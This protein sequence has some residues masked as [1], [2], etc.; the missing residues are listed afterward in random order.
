MTANGV[1]DGGGE[2]KRNVRGSRAGMES[3]VLSVQ[4]KRVERDVDLCALR[5]CDLSP[6]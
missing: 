2:Q 3:T 5:V 6:E 1:V 4:C